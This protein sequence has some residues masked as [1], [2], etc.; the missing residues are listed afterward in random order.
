[1]GSRRHIPY[2][3]VI[4]CFFI[5]MGTD[6]FGQDPDKPDLRESCNVCR[7]NVNSYS[8]LNVYFSDSEGEPEIICGDT[9]ETLYIS[10]LYSSN[11]QSAI[12][13]LRIIADIVKRSS[14][15]DGTLISQFFINE[16]IGTVAPC[17]NETCT[18]SIPLPVEFR[19]D[20]DKEYYELS[21]P[22]VAWTPNNSDLENGYNC[23]DY[24]PAQCSNQSTIPIEV[25][26]LAYSFEPIFDCS[27]GDISQTD[28]SFVITSLFGGN[29]TNP[30]D[31]EWEFSY[32]DG[33]VQESNEFSPSLLNKEGGTL[34]DA[35]P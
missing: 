11:S 15:D 4:F 6:S 31:T 13:N 2:I 19:I 24:R 16:Y 9:E 32:S 18:F 1:M 12:H 7:G 23:Q 3:I 5:G 17:P 28:V 26:A 20:C 30:Y 25:G 22:L 21:E 10:V 8:I 27:S 14:E 35:P 29:P 33:T 34:I